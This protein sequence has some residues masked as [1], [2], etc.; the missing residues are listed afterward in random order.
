MNNETPFGKMFNFDIE[1]G[2]LEVGERLPF[3]WKF[4][5]TI[6]GEF[7]ETFRWKLDGSSE[8][9]PILFTG[10]VMAPKFT[11]TPNY[12]DFGKASYSFP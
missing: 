11:F 1:R 12:I 5:S 8:M 2:I 3:E 7:S 10:H 9:L 6:L 4:K